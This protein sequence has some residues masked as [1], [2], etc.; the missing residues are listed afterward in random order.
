MGRVRYGSEDTG[1]KEEFSLRF[2]D[3]T[4][5]NVTIDMK[6]WCRVGGRG[7]RFM[8][9]KT[10]RLINSVTGTLKSPDKLRGRK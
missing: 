4:I 9:V 8:K 6:T 7:L 5:S 10:S 2:R 1:K 3:E